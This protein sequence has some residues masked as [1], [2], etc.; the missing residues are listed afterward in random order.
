MLTGTR[1]R[2]TLPLL[3]SREDTSSISHDYAGDDVIYEENSLVGTGHSSKH[4]GPPTTF[5][6]YRQHMQRTAGAGDGGV[7]MVAA[8]TTNPSSFLRE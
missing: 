1:F 2:E 6:D 4:V 5:E 8:G 7:L 3:M